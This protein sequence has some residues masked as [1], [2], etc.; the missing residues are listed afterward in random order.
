MKDATA[1]AM[2]TGRGQAGDGELC[3]GADGRSYEE[4]PSLKPRDI[5][6]A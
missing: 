3:D 6:G 4:R 5:L 2:K 1:I